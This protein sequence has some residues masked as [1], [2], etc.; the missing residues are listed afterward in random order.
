MGS[1]SWI[2]S[3]SRVLAAYLNDEAVSQK[4]SETCVHHA[5]RLGQPLLP[6]GLPPPLTKAL[7]QLLFV[8]LSLLL[9]SEDEQ[10]SYVYS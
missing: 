8:S 7:V 5:N 10:F 6:T 2:R 3:A 9:L 1:G 4:I